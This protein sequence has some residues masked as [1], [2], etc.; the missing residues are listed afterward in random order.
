M[1]PPQQNNISEDALSILNT[2][3]DIFEQKADFSCG[4]TIMIV[5]FYERKEGKVGRDR[6]LERKS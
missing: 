4:F 5:V 6:S 2:E 1:I 3:L